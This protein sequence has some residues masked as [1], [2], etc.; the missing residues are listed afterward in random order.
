MEW[1][2]EGFEGFSMGI[3]G[4]GGQNLYVSRRGVLQRI[5]HY[6]LNGDGYPDLLFASSQSM[7]ERPPVHIYPNIIENRQPMELPS[8]GTYTGIFTDLHHSG[9]DDLILACQ[10][11]G[12]HSDITSI[13]YFGGPEGLS[14][15]YRMELPVP[16]ATDV[17]AGDFNGDGKQELIFISNGS[18]RLFYQADQGFDPADLIDYAV[19]AAAITAE[20]LDG[21]GFCDLA[22]KTPEGR[23]GV[24]FG[25]A[26]GLQTDNICWIGQN[27]Q[28]AST[29]EGSSTEGMRA[30]ET[31]WRPSVVRLNGQTLLFAV[32]QEEIVL[33]QVGRGRQFEKVLMRHCPNAVHAVSAD[34]TGNG[35]EDLAVAVF[36]GRDETA[37]CRIYFGEQA[38]VSDRYVRIPVKGAVSV[39]IAQLDGPKAIFCRAGESVEQEVPSPVWRIN[40]DGTAE[41]VLEITGGD[42]A[43]IVAGHPQGRA[44]CDQIAVLNHKMNRLQGGE[45]IQIYLGGED[46]YQPERRVELA[47]H[48]AVDTTMCDFF[49]H[50]NPDVLVTNCFEDAMFLDHG[51]YIYTHDGNG[52]S[53]ER[54]VIL[55]TVRAHGCAIG[56]FRKSGY[57]DIAFGGF[58]NRELRIFHGSE[59][60]YSLERCTRIVLGPNEAGYEPYHYK[61]GDPW[62]AGTTP[63]EEALLPEF[64]Q[65]R[66]L[67]AADFNSDGW[68]DL[69]VSEILGPRC[70]ILWGGPEGFSK[71]RMTVL[72]TDGVASAAVAD[73]NKNGY[74]DL[75]LAQH[76]STRKKVRQESYI[77]VYWGGPEGYAENRKMQL[78]ASCANSVTVGDYSK[79]GWL[80][81]YATSYNN[82]RCRD[83]LSYLYKNDQGSFHLKNVQYLFNHSGSGC[84]S[85]DFNGDGYTDLAVA[86][87]KEYGNHC[88]HSFI[89]WGGPN[90]LSEA[91]KTVLPTVGPHGMSTVDPGNILDRSDAEY[92]FSPFKRL[93][94]NTCVQSIVWE[95]TCTS[96]SWVELALRFAQNEDALKDSVWIPVNANEDLLPL[97]I[98]GFVQY[99]LSLCARCGCGTPRINRV[100]VKMHKAELHTEK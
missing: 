39:T 11:N 38:G 78:P 83:L 84:V 50:G 74:P 25:S 90:G 14:E 43:R 62:A 93:P 99:R 67:L 36:T 24:I 19:Q 17:A 31:H 28:D 5:F 2:T 26:E 91:R 57:L 18:L 20:D 95:G 37:D 40:H 63:E 94:E 96:T 64:G 59:Q 21:D 15:N 79:S 7:N 45:N 56:D 41:K 81:I 9:Y 16:N 35:H 8:G 65:V 55:P 49:D 32:E 34:L 30:S 54:K 75:I 76:M 23:L 88:S 69:F 72:Q 33:Y 61:K 71:E 70:F 92:Y 60:G 53:P 48:S 58:R 3:M 1:V 82:G 100:V 6:D 13:I 73:L 29:A 4:N 46:G 77:T 10:N 42:C 80:D 47:G 98:K 51:S 87:H 68:L 12:T 85:G 97:N 66:W 44:E 27:Q 86:C 22:F 52:V 89:F